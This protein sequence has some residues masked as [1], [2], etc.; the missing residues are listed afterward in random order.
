MTTPN[1]IHD[2]RSNLKHLALAVAAAGLFTAGAQAATTT[3]T[4]NLGDPGGGTDIGG[5]AELAWIA[6]GN[7]PAGSMLRSISIHV[8]LENNIAT[9]TW[10]SD[11]NV[12]VGGVLLVGS[13]GGNPDWA[14]GQDSS[15]GATCVDTKAAPGD[16]PA[17]ID[18]HTTGVS[19]HNNWGEAVW[20]GTATVE[21]D[22][23]EPA[24]IVAFGPGATIDQGA[25]AIAWA[26]PF[27]TNLTTLAP[28]YLIT[29]GTCVPHSGSVQ[30]FTGPQTYTVTDGDMINAYTVTVTLTGA[31]NVTGYD[32]TQGTSAL[33][34]IA[35]LLAVVPSG[36]GLQTANINYSTFAGVVPGITDD[37]T[38]SVVWDGWLDVTR[39]GQGDYTFGTASDDGSVVYA[40]LNNDGVFDPATE[41][42]VNNN[43]DQGTTVRTGTVTLTMN[44]VHVLIGYYQN[45]GGLSMEAR[46]A[47][48][49]DVAWNSMQNVIGAGPYFTPTAP[50]AAPQAKM[51]SFGP[52][53]IIGT[54]SG[55]AAAI[56]WTVPYG[57]NPA[58][59]AATFTLSAG[60]TCTVG[61]S[62]VITGDTFDFANPLEFT[63]TSSDSLVTNVYTVTVTVAPNETTLI[64]NVGSGTWDLTTPNWKG[65]SSGVVTPFFNGVNV[66]FD[67]PAGGTI[68]IASG[69]L[70][71][72]IT[73]SATSGNYEFSGQPITTG[74]LAKSGGGTLKV[75]GLSP[76]TYGGGTIV[77][78]GLL[79]CGTMV[80][81][82]SP[83]L[84]GVLG[85]GPV[86]LGLG[87]TIEFDN[88]TTANALISNGGK[89]ASVNGWGTTWNGPVTLNANTTVDTTNGNAGGVT[90]GG[91]VSGAGGLIIASRPNG[92]TVVLS[93]NNSYAGPT[94]VTGGTLQCNATN[95]LG[96]GD[97]S[98]SAAAKVNLNHTGTSTVTSLTLGGVAQT[99]PGTYGS[100]A[101]GATFQNDTFFA[102]SGTVTVG[103]GYAGWASQYGGSGTPGD[104]FN[105]DGVQNGIA[106]FMN[107][108]G[109]AT[110][111]GVVNG[112]VTWANGGN[113]PSSAYG[114][115]FVVQTSAD[116]AN[117]TNVS[118]GDGNLNNTSGSVSY[119]F[120]T[121]QGKV[122]CRLVVTPN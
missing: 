94:S 8:V 106:F 95:A 47:K 41:L 2:L 52:G 9:D 58:S 5:G 12:K 29:S 81:G 49:T 87:A 27:G 66:I 92:P 108:T 69:I 3:S 11:L 20:S 28:A 93:V 7:L 54:L 16:F 34:P 33:N 77:S 40:D 89:F 120:P 30:D 102:G 113:I 65:Q 53:A 42:V 103:G 22:I 90:F 116:L 44:S 84:S 78:G 114:T 62:P 59:L 118:A 13:D 107:A 117:W 39:S 36:T 24:T 48:G 26:V 23:P 60:A 6:P 83:G 71:T 74:S 121:G 55:N 37:N 46:F 88:V 56:A 19:L 96:G 51:L 64:W 111:P 50:A 21:Y 10:A 68:S 32:T 79:H 80:G 85:T 104:D 35:N 110:L 99:A 70:P 15:N 119:T 98:I 86:T 67:N 17:T 57:S 45:G 100:V 38:F 72:S 14:N 43:A 18:L 122:F 4:I 82:I 63:V 112:K 97:L 31:M 75:D 76:N 73:V 115:Q 1:P 105:H 109:L 101:S 25:K 91:A 61:G